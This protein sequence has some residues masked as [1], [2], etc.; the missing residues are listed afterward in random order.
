MRNSILQF[1]FAI[2][3]LFV[4]AGLEEMLPHI[5]GVGFPILLATVL[6]VSAHR[7]NAVAIVFAVAAGAMED[8]IGSLPPMTSVS[9]FAIVAVAIRQMGCS[10]PA[11]L[12]AYPCYQIWLAL[13]MSGLGGGV[14]TRL[15][16]AVPIGLTMAI[17]V[18]AILWVTERKAV[19]NE[20]G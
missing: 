7:T 5:L 13:W 14:F 11:M 6:F 20:R 1:A 16:L 2:L 9:F 10:L 19:L 15:L 18:Q 4:G 17:A 3:G 12:F 8:A